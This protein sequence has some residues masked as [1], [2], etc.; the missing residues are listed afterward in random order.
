MSR[1]KWVL[2]LTGGI[3][4]GKTTVSNK[5]RDLG[6]YIIDADVISRQLVN[7]GSYG[8]K[9]IVEHF[10]EDVLNDDG[11]LNRRKLREIIFADNDA[12]EFLNN[13]LHPLIRSTIEMR[14][15]QADE[16]QIIVLVAPLLFENNLEY[17]CN[18][19]MCIYASKEEQIKRTAMRD[20]CSEE[21][22]R[23]IVESQ[24]PAEEKAKR[25][26]IVIESNFNN[27]RELSQFVE[28]NFE[29]IIGFREEYLKLN[30]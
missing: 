16:E 5:L 10:G 1:D 18:S 19:I 4:C 29:V 23:S 28:D 11:T 7:V 17:L 30:S 26:D 27:W 12:K 9:Q 15:S 25:S 6:C 24:M 2:G 14:I 20:K 8:L 3:G 22:A 13:L 21:L